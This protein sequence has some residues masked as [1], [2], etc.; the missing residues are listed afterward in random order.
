MKA[1]ER[2]QIARLYAAFCEGLRAPPTMTVSE[3]A[4]RYRKLSSEASSERGQWRNRPFQSEPMDCLSPSHPCERVVMMCASQMLKTE[5]ILN[6]L[7]FIIDQDP[8]PVLIV[9][10]REEDAKA[11]SKDRVGPMLRDTPQLAGKVADVRS[12]DSDNSTFHK[13]FVGGHV[14]FVGAIS[15]SG[16]AMRPIR[17][18]LMDEPDRYPA[19]AGSEGD[20]CM[21][22]IRRTDEFAWNKK[23]LMCSTPT[24]DGKSRIATAYEQSDQRKP[25]VPCPFCGE[26]QMLLWSQVEWPKDRPLEAGYRCAS[27]RELI[28]QHKKAWMLNQG[29]WVVTNPGSRIPGFHINQL[30]SSRKTWGSLAEEYVQVSHHPEQL[31]TFTNTVLAEVHTERGEAPEYQR[32]YD[33]REHWKIGTVP[34]GGLFLAAGADVQNDRI[35]VQ[36]LAFGR[37]REIWAIDYVVLDASRTT[38]DAVW[39]QLTEFLSRTYKHESGLNLHIARLAVDSGYATT[40]VYNWARR[41]GPGRVIVVKGQSSGA[42]VL[43]TPQAVDVNSR[44]KK[45]RAGV[46]VWPVNVSLLKKALYGD[47][48]LARPTDEELA[49]G[50]PYPAGYNH[51]PEFDSEY[52]KQLVAEELVTRSV[53]GYK[54]SEWVK[55]RNR[56]EALDTHNYARAAAAHVGIDRFQE[57]D[58]RALEASFLNYEPEIIAEP[59]EVVPVVAPQPSPKPAPLRQT[60]TMQPRQQPYRPVHSS[61]MRR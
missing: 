22:A 25:F 15:P 35:E 39:A 28:P 29:K 18:C 37:R 30:Y 24:I 32:L 36:V 60:Q 57:R 33:R 12:R 53:K 38:E 3:W 13:S 21:L 23:I 59:D 11:L 58:W 56:N 8:G 31:K 46:K 20:P 17:Y 2:N 34:K 9:E 49:A 16:L 27:C 26:M 5:T 40:L 52:F 45:S 6:F 1:G 43:G 7:G 48:R 10:P 14:T 19:S 42:A 55:T 4:A 41:Q 50:A 54:V 51:F 61:W 47:L 44:G